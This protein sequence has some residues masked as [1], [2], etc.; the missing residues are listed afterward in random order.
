MD[1]KVEKSLSRIKEELA[2]IEPVLQFLEMEPGESGQLQLPLLR[3][4]VRQHRRTVECVENGEPL[5]ASQYTNPVE[6]LSAMDLHWY[7][8]VQQMF[9]GA[10]GG[11][12]MHLVEDLAGMDELALPP[13]CCT[14]MRLAIYY[15]YAGLLPIPTAYLALTEPCDGVVGMHA[16]L[17]HHPD[18]HHVP[19]FAPDPPY[20]T[21][22]RSIQYYAG[23]MR[24]MVDFLSKQ[25]GKTLDMRRLK[26]IVEETNKGYALWMEYNE[27]RRSK[28]TPHGYVL[29]LSCFYMVNSSGAGE[30]AKTQWYEAMVADAEKRVRE[31]R[32][33]IPNQKL[34]VLWYDIQPFYFGQIASWL[35][36][37]WGAVIAM[38][39]VS[40]CPY[41]LIDTSTEDTIFY[42][43]AKRAFQHGPMIHQARGLADNVI[44]D[45]TRITKDYSIDAVIFP[46]HMGHKDMAAS[47]SLMRQV[48]RDIGV[49]FLHI[50]MDQADERYTSLDEIKGKISSFFTGTGL[51]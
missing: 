35:E 5:I 8:H 38:D 3:N 44:D 7:F 50:G 23:E 12:G 45:I 25:T 48:C 51:A 17:M 47:A 30:P 24:R 43:L 39:M 36:E 42:G 20:G 28:P 27:I 32:P 6:I 16:A 37:E 41:E 4:M 31:N 19:T 29:P 26:Q 2:A 34:R 22:P 21:D 1:A 11:G 49:P 14:F 46:G 18:W 9:A 40:F 15:A 10:A 33:E 13:D